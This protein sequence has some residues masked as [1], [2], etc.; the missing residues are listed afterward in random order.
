M[1]RIYQH[2]SNYEKGIRD[3]YDN[4]IVAYKTDKEQS[5]KFVLDTIKV[6]N[7]KEKITAELQLHKD[8]GFQYSSHA[9]FHNHT[10]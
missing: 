3:L 7:R 2:V 5:V 6:A 8:Q 4:S 10:A 1:A 9:Y